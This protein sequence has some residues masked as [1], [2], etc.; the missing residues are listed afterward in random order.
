MTAGDAH[1]LRR[2]GAPTWTLVAS[3]LTALAAGLYLWHRAGAKMPS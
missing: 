3:G 1:D 2:H